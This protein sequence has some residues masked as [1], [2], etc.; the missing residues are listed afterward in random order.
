MY[1]LLVLTGI[2]DQMGLFRY[3]RNN[4]TL[5]QTIAMDIYNGAQTKLT[6]VRLNLPEFT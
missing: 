3:P 1:V 2:E 6:L 5:L 4:L